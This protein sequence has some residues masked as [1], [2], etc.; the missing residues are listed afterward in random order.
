MAVEK[1]FWWEHNSR[2]GQFSSAKVHRTLTVEE[3][4]S[5]ELGS[6]EGLQAEVVDGF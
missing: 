6:L 2:S 1:V 4:G 3:D 5:Y